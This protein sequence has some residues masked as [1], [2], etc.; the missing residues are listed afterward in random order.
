ME[1]PARTLT[2]SIMVGLMFLG[3]GNSD[4]AQDRAECSEQLVGL[5]TC[6][7]YVG[8]DA[9]VPTKDCCAG[10]KAVIDKSKKCICILIKDRD[11]PELGLKINA[12]LAV[13]LPTVCHQPAPNIS[14]CTSLLKLPPNSPAAKEFES[15]GKVE[16]NANSTSSPNPQGTSKG[17]TTTKAKGA[18]AE[19]SDGGNIKRKGWLVVVTF[20]IYCLT[21]LF[22]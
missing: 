9:K 15:L 4:L 10:F 20:L 22:S 7:P 19:K 3:I 17:E 1:T 2:I 21:S 12:T 11:D 6:L 16:G 14:D 5:A 8:G 18:E 13:H